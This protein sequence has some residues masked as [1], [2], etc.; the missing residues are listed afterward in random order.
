M[1]TYEPDGTD[2]TYRIRFLRQDER[3]AFLDLYR[4]I[5]GSA[6]PE[7]FD[8]KYVENP[9]VS[10]VPV[11]VAEAESSGELAAARP[12]VPYRMV[13]DGEETLALRFG[14]TIVHEDHRRRGLFTATTT[15]AMDYYRRHPPAFA[16]NFPNELS[17]PGY[18][19]SGG[20]VVE[21][22]PTHY[23]VQDPAGLAGKADSSVL[24]RVANAGAGVVDAATAA[25]DA[26]RR[27]PDGVRVMRHERPPPGRLAALADGS[28]EPGI[29]ARRDEAF[30][31]WRFRN[32]RWEY[33]AYVAERDGED[34]A[35]LVTGTGE[36]DDAVVTN[37]MEPVPLDPG[38]RPRDATRALF[39]AVVRDADESDVVAFAGRS[40]D[41]SLL[42]RFGFL[43]DDRRPLSAVTSPS[44][45][46]AYDLTREDEPSWRV[47]G[48][49]LRR[50]E[51]W[52][53]TLSEHD[54]R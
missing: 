20:H 7:W 1:T 36:R 4:P 26:A 51:N 44:R 29:H 27:V 50:P 28:N 15:E 23:R 9:A 47:G 49:E 34:V 10:H 11:L 30:Y 21:E 18:L 38:A 33:R 52:A 6:S 25:V 13:V 48:L 2:E 43:P 31:G 41:R 42:R 8:W 32:P 12:Q 35:A 37:V 54:S 22:I 45:H 3:E 24:A 46:V 5:M 19:K 16:F 39:E 14:D 17:E 53:L 40:V